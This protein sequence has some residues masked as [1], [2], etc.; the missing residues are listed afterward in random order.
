MF[1]KLHLKVEDL[2]FV[3]YFATYLDQRSLERGVKNLYE[4]HCF[5]VHGHTLYNAAKNAW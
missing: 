2:L 4:L 3:K 1:D 5:P